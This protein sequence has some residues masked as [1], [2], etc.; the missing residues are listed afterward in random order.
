VRVVS[1][2]EK[3]VMFVKTDGEGTEINISEKE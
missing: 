1:D 2:S 3:V